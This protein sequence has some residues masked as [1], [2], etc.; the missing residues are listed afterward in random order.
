MKNSKD[1]LTE[2][3]IK[4]IIKEVLL[5]NPELLEEWGLPSWKDVKRTFKR[6]QNA[7]RY[8]AG[9]A[10]NKVYDLTQGPAPDSVLQRGGG[11]VDIPASKKEQ[12][13]RRKYKL[14]DKKCAQTGDPK[15]CAE[16]KKLLKK[17]HAIAQGDTRKGGFERTEWHGDWEDIDIAGGK[18]IG[19]R[20]SGG[21]TSK[22]RYKD[23]TEDTL[24]TAKAATAIA[25]LGGAGMVA[26][27]APGMLAKGPTVGKIMSINPMQHVFRKMGMNEKFASIATLLFDA[28][29][30]FSEQWFCGL[31]IKGVRI[32]DDILKH[33]DPVHY[34]AIIPLQRAWP[35]GNTG[36]LFSRDIKFGGNVPIDWTNE[37]Q[38]NSLYDHINQ[39]MMNDEDREA[40]RNLRDDITQKVAQL[41]RLAQEEDMC[42]EAYEKLMQIKGAQ[43]ELAKIIGKNIEKETE[44]NQKDLDKR[45]NILKRLKGD[46]Q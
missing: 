38:V 14:A 22:D 3:E 32:Y 37:K 15:D 43:E 27:L 13:A 41:N 8:W 16:A 39:S 34:L 9:R 6:A 23:E 40:A 1:Q 46:N 4:K 26:K 21:F 2:Q 29:I 18:G 35:G 11:K 5:E 31:N 44:K 42:P 28:G 17:A 45:K 12:E 19:W 30:G 20:T 7:P 25:A 36:Q 10:A 33:V 24:Q